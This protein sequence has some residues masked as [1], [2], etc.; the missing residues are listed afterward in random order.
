MAMNSTPCPEKRVPGR[1]DPVT[2]SRRV[3]WA[4]CADCHDPGNCR[5]DYGD[6]FRDDLGRLVTVCEDLDDPGS[7]CRALA[8]SAEGP[9]GALT[10]GETQGELA[11]AVVLRDAVAL[12]D[13]VVGPHS[14]R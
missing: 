8:E 7:R 9:E 1:I 13:V 12:G 11:D 10:A 5:G 14:A 4:A 2:D 3:G 6:E